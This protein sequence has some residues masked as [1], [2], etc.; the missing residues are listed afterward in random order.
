VEFVTEKHLLTGPGGFRC[1]CCTPFKC[2]PNEAKVLSA[3]WIR[4]ENR[5]RLRALRD[6]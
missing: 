6:E 2:H 3:R 1:R 5:R 4:R